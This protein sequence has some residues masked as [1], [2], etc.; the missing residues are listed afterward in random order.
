MSFHAMPRILYGLKCLN[1]HLDEIALK[2][3]QNPVN[4]QYYVTICILMD[5]YKCTGYR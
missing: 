5:V 4:Y 1:V 2:D 3:I